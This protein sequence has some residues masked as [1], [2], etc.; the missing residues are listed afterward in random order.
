MNN[1]LKYFKLLN[2]ENNNIEENNELKTLFK[3]KIN[4]KIIGNIIE[5]IDTDE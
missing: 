1:Y 2:E 4:N 3:P 5:Y